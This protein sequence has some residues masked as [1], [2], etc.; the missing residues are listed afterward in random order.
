MTTE[1][2]KTD[3]VDDRGGK[4]SAKP[5]FRTRERIG[6]LFTEA[7][8]K[9]PWMDSVGINRLMN[10][11]IASEQFSSY[12]DEWRRLHKAVG[13]T[14]RLIGRDQ[15]ADQFTTAVPAYT[16]EQHPIDFIATLLKGRNNPISVSATEKR[17]SMLSPFRKVLSDVLQSTGTAAPADIDDLAQVFYNKFVAKDDDSKMDFSK[18]DASQSYHADESLTTAVVSYIKSL[19]DRKAAGDTTLSKLEEK[20]ANTGLSVQKNLTS[21]A[22]TEVNKKVGESVIGNS[23]TILIVAVAILGLLLYLIFKK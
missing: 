3:T 15:V 12:A 2:I 11:D 23:K 10:N 6:K 1:E 14:F 4:L 13:D 16:A 17:Y 8:L 19:S 7:G 9:K 20:I 18:M 21:I 5:L 22:E